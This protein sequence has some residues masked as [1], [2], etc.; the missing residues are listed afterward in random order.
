MVYD[1]QSDQVIDYCLS[2]NNSSGHVSVWSPDNQQFVV[3]MYTENASES[4]NL[5]MLI[6]IKQNI[7]YE[8]SRNMEPLEWM[9]SFP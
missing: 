9:N 2:A 5:T 6:D 7:A 8:I 4:G 3:N 1:V